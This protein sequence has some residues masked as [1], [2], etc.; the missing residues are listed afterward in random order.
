MAEAQCQALPTAFAKMATT[1]QWIHGIDSYE[2]MT[3][4]WQQSRSPR[5]EIAGAIPTI[6][7]TPI[8]SGESDAR[9]WAR[10]IIRNDADDRSSRQNT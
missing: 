10:S 1:T 8:A 2:A 7:E 4:M 5:N 3:N 9:D 6:K